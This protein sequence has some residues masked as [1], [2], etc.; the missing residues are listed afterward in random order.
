MKAMQLRDAKSFDDWLILAMVE[1]RLDQK[2]R[3]RQLLTYALHRMD[4]I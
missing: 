3:A 2:P 1:W 4:K